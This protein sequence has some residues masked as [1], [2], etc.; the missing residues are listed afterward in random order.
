MKISSFRIVLVGLVLWGAPPAEGREWVST[1]GNKLEADFVSA[2]A[3]AVT[4]VRTSDGK[5]FTLPLERLSEADRK[6]V[7]ENKDKEPEPV[8]IGGEYAKLITGDWALSEFRGLPFALYATS[9]LDASKKYPLVL[10]LHGKSP[11][12][13]NG[14]QKGILRAFAEAGVYDEHP[15]ILVAPLCYQPYGATGS[16]WGDEPGEKA[17]ALVEELAENLPVDEDRIYC[18]G[19][20]MGGGGTASLICDEPKLF[21]AGIVICGWPAPGSES[22]FKKVPVWAFHGSA[23]PTVSPKYMRDLAE[24]LKRE[25][26]FKYTEFEGAGHGI[27]GQ[28]WQTEGVFDWLFSKKK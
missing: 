22:V 17:I 7:S 19:S 16:G 13:E 21:A 25:D 20:S 12:N 28:V 14:K 6:W 11:N 18:L 15:A 9:T 5:E 3:D 1:D 4:I 10:G 8:P 26:S 2:T 23:D 24:S 27:S